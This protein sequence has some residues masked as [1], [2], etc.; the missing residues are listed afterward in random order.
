MGGALFLAVVG[1]I[2][3]TGIL[4]HT[5]HPFWAIGVAFTA[6]AAVWWL[7]INYA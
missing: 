2:I 5:G 6:C 1:G 3:G 4:F 7:L